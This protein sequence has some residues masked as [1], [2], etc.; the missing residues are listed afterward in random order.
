MRRQWHVMKSGKKSYNEKEHNSWE[1]VESCDP[2]ELE[3]IW[4]QEDKRYNL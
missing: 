1:I 4:K 2:K 3:R